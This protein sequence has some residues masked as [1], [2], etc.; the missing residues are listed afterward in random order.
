MTPQEVT[1]LVAA[2]S[3][4]LVPATV[5]VGKRLH[6]W[7]RDHRHVRLAL[8]FITREE[9]E[10]HFDAMN[11]TQSKQHGENRDFL[12]TIR[13]EGHQRELRI[14]G[15]IEALATDNRE[16]RKRVDQLFVLMTKK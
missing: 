7:W 14:L 12:D 3:V 13:T 4:I 15:S 1:I 16:T 6:A 2:V 10:M 8:V 5:A 9:Y 11:S